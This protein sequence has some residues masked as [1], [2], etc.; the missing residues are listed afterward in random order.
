MFAI[1]IVINLD[2]NKKAGQCVFAHNAPTPLLFL[3]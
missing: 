1:G 3:I 2:L